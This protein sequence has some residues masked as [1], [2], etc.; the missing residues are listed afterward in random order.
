MKSDLKELGKRIRAVRNAR[1]LTQ[2]Y[3]AETLNISPSHYSDIEMG[4]TNFGIDIFMRITEVLQVSAD[5]L[6]RTDVPSVNAVYSA[7][8]EEIF[9]DCSNAEKEAML[10][11]LQNMKNVFKDSK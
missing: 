10:K 4:K 8:I 3:L 1:R 2:A 5:E 11:T 6:L 7:E 9:R